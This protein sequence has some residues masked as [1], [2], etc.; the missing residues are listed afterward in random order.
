MVRAM[1]ELDKLEW[2]IL[3]SL[4]DDWECSTT[5]CPEIEGQVDDTN[6]VAILRCLFN[7]H[8]RGLVTLQDGRALTLEDF[9]SERKDDFDT[10]FWFGLT[11]AGRAEWEKFSEKYSGASV[12]WTRAWVGCI[13]Y[14]RGRSYVDG[15]SLDVCTEALKQLFPDDTE[16][17]IDWN[18]LESTSIEG[19]HA[20]YH[21]YLDGG[22]RIS[23]QLKKKS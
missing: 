22:Q 2:S 4:S 20:K 6:R 18:T 19:F 10:K 16:W 9:L 13:S 8:S 12:D 3:N 23:F 7:L 15:T 14:D 5:I 21:K 17:E 11:E 1:S